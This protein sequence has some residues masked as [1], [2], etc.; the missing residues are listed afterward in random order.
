MAIDR[1]GFTDFALSEVWSTTLTFQIV[2]LLQYA[3]HVAG[4]FEFHILFGQLSDEVTERL[5]GQL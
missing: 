5:Y 1:H 3:S 4:Q 2:Q